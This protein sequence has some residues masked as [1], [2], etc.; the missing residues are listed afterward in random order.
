MLR[1]LNAMINENPGPPFLDPAI[2]KTQQLAEAFALTTL[3]GN[4]PSTIGPVVS[5]GDPRLIAP[6]Q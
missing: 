3:R 5:H 1:V 4:R 6:R 2:E